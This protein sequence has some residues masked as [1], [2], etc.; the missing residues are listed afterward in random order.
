ME[1]K[2][3]N[4]ILGLL[5]LITAELNVKQVIIKSGDLVSVFD[6]NTLE[7]KVIG[8]DEN[9]K[10]Y[11]RIFS[12]NI[13]KDME[14]VRQKCKEGHTQRQKVGI[15]VRQPLQR[16]VLILPPVFHRTNN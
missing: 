12:G 9:W 1:V 7:N 6:Y 15:N 3:K 2:L 8:I 14:V 11:S 16:I 10:L 5:E 13:L 4:Y